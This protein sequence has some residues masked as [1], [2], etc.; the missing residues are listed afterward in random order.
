MRKKRLIILGSTGSIGKQA[1]QV[2][3]ENAERFE[4]VGLSGNTNG[5]LLA[6]QAAAFN[7]KQMALANDE[8]EPLVQLVEKVEADMVLVAVTGSA[9]LLPTLA[10]IRSGKDIAL[11]NKEA[12]VMAGE[13]VMEEVGKHGVQL[14]PV[15]SEHSA[16]FQCLQK[17]KKEEVDKIILTCSGGPFFGK[18][19]EELKKVTA[20]DAL[21]HPTWDMG[22]KISIDSATLVNKGFEVIEAHH[23]FGFDYDQIEVRIH[24]QSIAHGIIQ[25]KDGNSFVQ[26]S[27]PDMRLPIQYALT[28]PDRLPNNYPGAELR[29]TTLEFFEADSDTFR[30][31]KMGYHVGRQG[32]MAPAIFTVANDNAV[33][34]FLEGKI[35]FLEIYDRIESALREHQSTRQISVDALAELIT[36]AL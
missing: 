36:S 27:P 19:R 16:I 4:V 10:A 28:Y 33:A 9:G 14:I 23:L 3:A 12:I 22:N 30:G 25:L 35:G 31:I 1:L 21:K 34:D 5:E 26:I 13:L 11:A 24:P 20:E 8:S 2:I 32:G 17:V 15:D 18:T 7:V 29:K 6:K